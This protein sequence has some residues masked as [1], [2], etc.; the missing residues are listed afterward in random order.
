MHPMQR[1]KWKIV[2]NKTSVIS[3]LPL[4]TLRAGSASQPNVI[5]VSAAEHHFLALKSDGTVMAMGCN[6]YGQLGNKASATEQ[7]AYQVVTHN[8]EQL[9]SNIKDISAGGFHS[10]ALDG[11]GQVWAWGNN[12]EGQLGIGRMNAVSSM[13]AAVPVVFPHK[14]KIVEISAGAAFSL[15]LDEQ[16]H[17]WAW[18]DNEESQLGIGHDN[19]GKSQYVPIQVTTGNGLLYSIQSISAGPYH[20]LALGKDGVIWGWGANWNGALGFDKG[21]NLAKLAEDISLDWGKEVIFDSG[22]MVCTPHFYALMDYMYEYYPHELI[23]Q[24]AKPVSHDEDVFSEIVAGTM[25]SRAVKADGSVWAWGYIEDQTN[26]EGRCLNGERLELKAEPSEDMEITT[27]AWQKL[28]A[29][30]RGSNWW[31][32]TLCADNIPFSPM[33]IDG[34]IDFTAKRDQ[35]FFMVYRG[36]YAAGWVHQDGLLDYS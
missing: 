6:Q 7:T 36:R 29:F 10:L 2:L 21:M 14:E 22:G 30:S 18:G 32:W 23:W 1:K 5:K 17:V 20:S 8:E 33:K 9:L 15:A 26:E 35:E 31:R 3:L 16:G 4:T 12:R 28:A 34:I 13:D 27:N 19:I 11:Q 25:Q 24:H